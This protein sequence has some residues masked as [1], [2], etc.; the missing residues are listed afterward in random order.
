MTTPIR[1]WLRRMRMSIA[2]GVILLSGCAAGAIGSPN[3][4]V[5]V[6]AVNYTGKDLNAVLFMDPNSDKVAGGSGADPYGGSGAMCCFAL[7]RKWHAG[8]KVKV[9]YDWW[10]G[11]SANRKYEILTTEIPPYPTEEP[12]VLWALFY[13]DGSVEVFAS[14]VDPGHDKWPGK[15]K[16]WP[17][18]SR[19]HK[20]KLWEQTYKEEGSLIPYYRELIAGVTD[21]ELLKIWN[22]RARYS[23]DAN[24]A[25]AGPTDPKFKEAIKNEAKDDLAYAQQRLR[26][27]ETVKP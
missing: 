23:K 25:F 12:G 7:P 18:P 27:L 2:F 11:S 20:L 3:D 5:A 16:H 17:I 1:P 26:D 10:T 8:I 9:R 6:T 14:A 22:G 13:E 21:E 19:E 4:S 15:L 24:K